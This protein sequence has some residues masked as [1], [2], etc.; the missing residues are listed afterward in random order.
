MK[1]NLTTLKQYLNTDASVSE[2][3]EKLT[4]IGLEVEDVQDLAA[5]LKGYILAEIRVVEQHPNADK[6]HVLRVF[7]GKEDVQIVCGA[8]N[9][10]VG[11]KSILAQPGCY[12]PLFK[13]TIQV[14]KLRGVESNGMMCAEDELGIGTDHQGIVD[15][16]TDLPAGTPAADVLNADVIFDVNV[17]PN[18][19]DCLGIKGIARDLAATGIGTLI[20]QP[21]TEIAGS[22][23]S[24]WRPSAA[25][26]RSS[27]LLNHGQDADGGEAPFVVFRVLFED[28]FQRAG[29][30]SAKAEFFG[31]SPHVDV[32]RHGRRPF[33]GECDGEVRE[34]NLD[35]FGVSAHEH[36]LLHE[37]A[38]A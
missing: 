21:K 1:F 3:A 19:P 25:V 28:R 2:I 4:M 36:D 35:F 7:N 12:V 5:N 23:A 32:D 30:A 14:S 15:L 31:E 37:L 13:E 27:L 17:T 24:R 18:R 11:M 29:V 6:L 26:L 33:V 8:P 34:A 38:S 22:F 9:V 16:T 20:E 10:R